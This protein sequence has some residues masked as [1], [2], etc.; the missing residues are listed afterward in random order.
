MGSCKLMGSGQWAVE[1]WALLACGRAQK[2][3]QGDHERGKDPPGGVQAQT[4][5]RQKRTLEYAV[6]GLSLWQR[7][8]EQS[9]AEQSRAEQSRA[10]QSR[11]EQSRRSGR[12]SRVE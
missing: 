4:G 8:R 1:Q 7:Q 11:A 2:A 3:R 6:P 12:E 5:V 10:E 9:R